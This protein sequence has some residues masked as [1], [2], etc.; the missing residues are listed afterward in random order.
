MEHK[1]SWRTW[2][3][4]ARFLKDGRSSFPYSSYPDHIPMIGGIKNGP[5]YE[6]PAVF[7]FDC[8]LHNP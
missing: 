5:G 4:I 2:I 3:F 8:L 6:A 7:L 1:A